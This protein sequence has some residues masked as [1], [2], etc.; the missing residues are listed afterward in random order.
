MELSRWHQGLTAERSALHDDLAALPFHRIITSSHD[1][2]M[3]TALRE[4]GKVPH[5]GRYHYRG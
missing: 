1:P 3:E 5:V 2:L 4:A